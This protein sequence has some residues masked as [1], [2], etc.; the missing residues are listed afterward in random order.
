MIESYVQKIV[1]VD[2]QFLDELK[3]SSLTD[4]KSFATPD[5]DTKII[6]LPLADSK[7]IT[8]LSR[9]IDLSELRSGNI[10]VKP[11]YTDQFVPVDEFS[12]DLVLRRY[13]VLVQ[14]CIAL[15]AKK[16][17]IS[18]I[19]DVNLENLDSTNIGGSLHIGTPIGDI[20]G[21]VKNSQ[22]SK[23]EAVLQSIMKMHTDASGGEP[24][25][26]E[27]DHIMDMYGLRRES[28]FMDIYNMCRVSTN[29]LIRHEVSL[30]FSK[31]IKRAFDSSLQAKVKAMSKL[32]QGK[33]EFE[34]AK[35]CMEKNK[36]ATKLS[37]TIEF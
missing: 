36:S 8:E 10:L 32:Y 23:N 16:V 28:L 19:E 31:D 4:Y 13:G 18:N 17:K 3:S 1:V 2:Q 26:N 29:R 14:L 33:A 27:A 12:E 22:I 34:K 21:G 7:S 35:S 15:G 24:N 37:V 9:V 11:G 5:I 25:L 6:T 30:D 20:E